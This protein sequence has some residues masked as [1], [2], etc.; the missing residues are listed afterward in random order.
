MSPEIS[1]FSQELAAK[2]GEE[3][4]SKNCSKGVSVFR[5]GDK[6]L[7]PWLL[8]KGSV[9]L[10]KSSA[11]GKEQ[12]V[13]EIEPGEVFAEVPLF[14]TFGWY[15]ITARCATAAELRLLP[16]EKAKACLQAD[17]KL[18]WLAACALAGRLSDFRET[19]FDLTLADAQ[20]RLLR[21]LVR[22]LEGKPNAELGIVRL[23][24]NHQD[25][26]LLL[27]IR[28]ESLSRALT[29][30]EEAG[31]LKRLARQTVQLFPKNISKESLEW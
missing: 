1:R 5:E 6:Y 3:A 14:K 7:G 18:A 19:F 30:L 9:V 4:L 8:V 2:V 31:K 20:K 22:R 23:G 28:P 21:Y 25:L 15:P 11:A 12:L 24:I 26:A 16:V 17:P 29:E 27:G 13:R 10:V